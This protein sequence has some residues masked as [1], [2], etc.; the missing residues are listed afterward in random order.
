MIIYFDTKNRV[1]LKFVSSD[2]DAVHL[3]IHL[4]DTRR[5]K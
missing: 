4:L 1:V 5:D 2:R 3:I